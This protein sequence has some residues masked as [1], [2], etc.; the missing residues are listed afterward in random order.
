MVSAQAA[1]SRPPQLL[2][3][4]DSLSAAYGIPLQQGWVALLQDRLKQAGYP[5]Q[6]VNASITGD[7]TGGGLARLPATLQ[8]HHPALVVIELGGNDGLRGFSLD[9]MQANLER[10]VKLSR[11]SGAEVLLL[12]VR[13]PANY[14][15]AYDERFRQVYADVSERTQVPLVPFFLV[16]IAETRAGMQADGIHPDV[17]AQPRILDNIWP[18]LQP[19]LSAGS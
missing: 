17:A 11:A 7:T 13:L 9:Q 15:S 3:L 16:G 1:D 8:D 18:A 14:G 4:G 19:L 12:G 10:L 6:V 5:H 2:V